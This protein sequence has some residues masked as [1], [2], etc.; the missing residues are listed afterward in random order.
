MATISTR[1]PPSASR[2]R[3]P[4]GREELAR[5]DHYIFA[6][7][8]PAVEIPG[9]LLHAGRV[10]D[11]SQLTG[12]AAAEIGAAPV[13]KP[14]PASASS[15]RSARSAGTAGSRGSRASRASRTS[16]GS[17]YSTR[18][19]LAP[20]T[21][22]KREKGFD[23]RSTALDQ[24]R[25]IPQYDALRDRHLP[26]SVK[27]KL[28]RSTYQAA[29]HTKQERQRVKR[30]A[31]PTKARPAAR[32]ASAGVSRGGGGSPQRRARSAARSG[33]GGGVR[34]GRAD[35]T[36]MAAITARV[37]ELWGELRIPERECAYYQHQLF[38][39]AD[40]A[41]VDT[42]VRLRDSLEDHRTKTLQVL[43]CVDSR[44]GQLERLKGLSE[45]IVRNGGSSSSGKAEWMDEMSSLL[46]ALRYSTFECAEAIMEWRR[47]LC[48][49]QAFLWKGMNYLLKMKDDMEV[50][51]A[52]AG[53]LHGGQDAAAVD[54]F[55]TSRAEYAR[56][57]MEREEEVQDTLFQENDALLS[58]NHW[59]PTLNLGQQGGKTK[60]IRLTGNTSDGD[61]VQ[62]GSAGADT[63]E[64]EAGGAAAA[65]ETAEA[66]A[67]AFWHL[68]GSSGEKVGWEQIEQLM[69]QAFKVLESSRR[70]GGSG[71]ISKA[72][73][74]QAVLQTG[75]DLLQRGVVARA[76]RRDKGL[77]DKVDRLWRRLDGLYGQLAF[78]DLSWEEV[79]L[80]LSACKGR[81][82]DPRTVYLPLVRPETG[83]AAAAAAKELS[84]GCKVAF[85][86]IFR[87]FDSDHDGA[88]S[89]AELNSFQRS[90]H[91]VPLDGPTLDWIFAN[92][93]L[94]AKGCLTL[95]GF[96]RCVHEQAIEN[97]AAIVWELTQLG[98]ETA[99]ATDAD[100]MND[101]LAAT[102]LGGSSSKL[103]A[104][105]P[106]AASSGASTLT[107]SEP[108]GAT[109]SAE[110]PAEPLA[111]I[112]VVSRGSPVPAP[113]PAP[114]SPVPPAPAPASPAPAPA[115]APPPPVLLA[116]A[117]ALPEEEKEEEEEEE[118][119]EEVEDD[120][121]EPRGFGFD[122]GDV[123]SDD[124]EYDM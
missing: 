5:A 25:G 54:E 43:R 80:G 73:L 16:T 117:P 109:G 39:R 118:D 48:Q 89:K 78:Q 23:A 99:Q 97:E 61:A 111:G 96:L 2:S 68:G 59:L 86:E 49:P 56:L 120:D 69:Q 92:H 12:T 29:A 33:G 116:P 7:Q 108:V 45:E 74:R 17:R 50:V 11:T 102:K 30:T 37:E 1:R 9:A 58:S 41:G 64:T 26:S 71:L 22:K 28:L 84:F 104:A 18:S 95:S 63:A 24:Q 10:Y 36:G 35:A 6:G 32:P 91:G 113:A 27:D 53:R 94:D 65:A 82:Y 15:K 106:P 14:R 101:L 98:Y 40:A 93:Q 55:A 103:A 70:V 83:A 110:P 107:S 52:A 38:K 66:E 105:D 81:P 21:E 121:D 115:P 72:A 19:G 67:E 79:C 119:D 87:R 88:L 46:T 47:T 114:A 3:G 100:L 13:R 112:N 62:G 42:M 8:S 123:S 51:D 31:T 124:A 44:E 77:R 122:G 34:G 4:P 57:V 60:P 76:R 85:T 75:Q 90:V 20:E